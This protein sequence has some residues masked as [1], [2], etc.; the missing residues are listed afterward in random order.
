MTDE[1]TPNTEIDTTNIAEIFHTALR[2]AVEGKASVASW[3]MLNFLPDKVRISFYEHLKKR[4]AGAHFDAG[5]LR[6]VALSWSDEY[7]S[8]DYRHEVKAFG[9]VLEMHPSGDWTSIAQFARTCGAAP[10]ATWESDHLSLWVDETGF[11]PSIVIADGDGLE[12]GR[13]EFGSGTVGRGDAKNYWRASIDG[14]P[15]FDV[16]GELDAAGAVV[17]RM[18]KQVVEARIAQREQKVRPEAVV[19]LEGID[20]APD[21]DAEDNADYR[22]TLL[23]GEDARILF[24]RPRTDNGI[25]SL[26]YVFGAEDPSSTIG[27][28]FGSATVVPADPGRDRVYPSSIQRWLE[29]PR[30]H[31]SKQ[32]SMGTDTDLVRGMLHMSHDNETLSVRAVLMKV[33][34]AERILA[35]KTTTF[36]PVGYPVPATAAPSP[37]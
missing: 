34:A 28:R 8:R 3:N 16:A 1:A 25:H 21:I 6:G 14:L 7:D 31:W 2:K 15:S 10:E 30:K 4:L 24:R 11:R 37:V 29:D 26:E 23:A 12:I 35:E 18:K 17:D 5:A 36:S 22:F 27:Y 19:A 9:A 32:I 13:A 20:L 33:G